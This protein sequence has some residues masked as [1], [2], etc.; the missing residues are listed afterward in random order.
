[1]FFWYK[2]QGN[3]RICRLE[4]SH[5]NYSMLGYN[6]NTETIEVMPACHENFNCVTQINNNT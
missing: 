4:C 2:T 1:M 5:C 3:V 6:D